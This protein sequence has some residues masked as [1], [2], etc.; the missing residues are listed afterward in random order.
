MFVFFLFDLIWFTIIQSLEFND[1][2]IWFDTDVP[3]IQVESVA[4][5]TVQEEHQGVG[6]HPN[7][8]CGMW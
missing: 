1:Y 7:V 2:S 3:F 6:P 8:H 4:F 5:A